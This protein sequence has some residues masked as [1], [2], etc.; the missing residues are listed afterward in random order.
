MT[1]G[2]A[3]PCIGTIFSIFILTI[4]MIFIA[5]LGLVVSINAIRV[6]N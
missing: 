5:L 4:K 2:N 6:I 3:N 1:Y